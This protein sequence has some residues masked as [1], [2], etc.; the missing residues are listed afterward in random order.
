MHTSE[1][2]PEGADYGAE[3]RKLGSRSKIIKKGL[4]PRSSEWKAR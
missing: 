1:Q 2:V 3:R 4:K